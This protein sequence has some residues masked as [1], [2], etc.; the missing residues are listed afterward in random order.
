[1]AAAEALRAGE[2]DAAFVVASPESSVVR[3]LLEAEG[4]GAMSLTRAEAYTRRYR[5]LSRLLLPEG[6]IDFER[7]RLKRAEPGQNG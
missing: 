4:V 5:F 7:A 6:V 2:A 3:K 1:M